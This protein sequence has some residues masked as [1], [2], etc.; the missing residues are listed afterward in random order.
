MEQSKIDAAARLLYTLNT[1]W[2][3]ISAASNEGKP[4]PLVIINDREQ[5]EAIAK[6]V[7]G[8]PSYLASHVPG[9]GIRDFVHQYVMYVHVVFDAEAEEEGNENADR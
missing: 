9:V 6:D 1:S 2:A 4:Q 7:Y 5:F 3:A 8:T